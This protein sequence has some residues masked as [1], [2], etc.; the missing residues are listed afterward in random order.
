MEEVEM[1]RDEPGPPCDDELEAPGCDV[2]LPG[3]F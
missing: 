3:W 2:E 1:E